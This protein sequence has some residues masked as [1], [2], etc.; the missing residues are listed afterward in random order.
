MLR[1]LL[2]EK[3][4]MA[5]TQKK[6]TRERDP[7]FNPYRSTA[8][9][10]A[11]I[12]LGD[13]L[14]GF[15]QRENRKRARK[16]KDKQWLWDIGYP[17]LA[18]LA[19]HYLNGSPGNGLVVARA[20]SKLG[21]HS[22]YYPP[23][24]TRS[25]P[26]LLDDFEGAG[27]LEQKTGVFSG[28]PGKSTR[29]TIRAGAKLIDAIKKHQIT[30][31]DLAVSAAEEVI[32]L[33]RAKKGYWDEGGQI[34]Y[35][36]TPVTERL[37]DEV[38]WLNAWLE[39]ADIA[40]EPFAY[41]RPVDVRARRL[42]R[43]FANANFKSGGRLFRGFWEN[44][45]KRARLLGLLIE[46]E[47]VVE[48]DY[49]QLNPMLAYAKVGR[50]PPSGDAY[51]LPG[52]EQ[53]RD[54]VKRVFNALLFD[55]GPRR[56]FPKGEAIRFPKKVKIGDVIGAI[57]A[58]HPRLRSVLSTGAGFDLMFRESE[59]MMNVLEGLRHQGIV[60]L[61]VFDGV[62]VK[63][64]KAETAKRVMKEQFNKAT[65][66]EIQVRLEHGLVPKV[67]YRTLCKLSHQATRRRKGEG[68]EEEGGGRRRGTQGLPLGGHVSGE[69]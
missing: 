7:W 57:C 29:T 28:L 38:R 17:L 43:Y 22:R 1:G 13:M 55:T 62:I 5:K 39:S 33:K 47:G 16:P 45:P 26:K 42:F 51:T 48:L 68:G 59:I 27:Y 32:I 8:S 18:D 52:L 9:W 31:D 69:K 67:I 37:R 6:T 66:L 56:S 34:E 24:F 35:K 3:F 53:Y 25:F 11:A 36:D 44:L 65:G 41:S 50:S 61:P 20:K 19:Y 4:A 10:K 58:K 60:G 2:N 46:G 14:Y 15:E 49:S 30:F 64:S 54:G 63:A 23:Y 21:K 12:A 40:F